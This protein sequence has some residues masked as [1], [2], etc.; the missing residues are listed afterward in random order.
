MNQST[1]F[2]E[3]K[4]ILPKRYAQKLRQRIIDRHGISY[5]YNY[6][7]QVINGKYWSLNSVI[8][9]EAILWAEEIIKENEEF[10]RKIENLKTA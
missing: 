2:Q 8:V 7:Q 10:T 6:I 9:K 1:E 5:H 3:I 4:K